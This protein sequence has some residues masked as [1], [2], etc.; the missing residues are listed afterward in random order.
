M[1]VITLAIKQNINTQ[2]DSLQL[3]YTDNRKALPS[4][5]EPKRA[6]PKTAVLPITPR[7]NWLA[8]TLA[9]YRRIL[10]T[11]NSWPE[12]TCYLTIDRAH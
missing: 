9:G 1:L 11:A 8:W 7:E 3:T 6:V 4:G 2:P 10:S 12:S 5:L